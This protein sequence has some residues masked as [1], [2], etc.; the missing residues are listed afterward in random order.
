MILQIAIIF[1]FLALGE[2]LVWLTGLPLPSS[3]VGMLLLT[4]AL[5]LGLL[6]LDRVE[7]GANFLVDNLSFFFIPAGV[8]VM[9]C[10]G[11]IA[12]QW[13][14]IVTACVVSTF[15]VIAVTGHIHQLS[16]RF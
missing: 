14:P 6:R 3:I 15:I 1:A 12:D 10:L 7:K 2:A 16:R 11:L 13:L 4:A 9:N 5:Q 8:G